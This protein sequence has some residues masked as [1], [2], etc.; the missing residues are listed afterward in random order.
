MSLNSDTLALTANA[1]QYSASENDYFKCYTAT[2]T[3]S[4]PIFIVKLIFTSDSGNKLRVNGVLLAS[5]YNTLLSLAASSTF[6][7]GAESPLILENLLSNAAGQNSALQWKSYQEDRNSIWVLAMKTPRQQIAT[8][9]E[10]SGKRRMSLCFINFWP[11]FSTTDGIVLPLLNDS[12]VTSDVHSADVI[13]T[14]CHN[15]A[16]EKDC[17]FLVSTTTHKDVYACVT[18]PL[19]HYSHYTNF[20]NLIRSGCFKGVFGCVPMSPASGFFKFPL[21]LNYFKYRDHHIYQDTNQ[22]AKHTTMDKLC[23]KNFCTLI[24]SHDDGGSREGIFDVLSAIA[25]I[26]SPGKYKNNTSNTRLNSIGN[27]KYI[28]EFV[29]HICPVS[30]YCTKI[31][32]YNVEKLLNCCL[33]GAIPIYY[34]EIDDIDKEIFNVHRI[35]CYDPK[36]LE[37]I[38]AVRS[39]VDALWRD[40]DKLLQFYRQAIFQ[41]SAHLACMRM[42]N[43]LQTMLA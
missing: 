29:F 37:S 33:G 31:P 16:N 18:E 12:A 15:I 34:G 27:V 22:N 13:I 2:I 11:G 32:G 21:Y 7:I 41:D 36:Q 14:G 40:K 19:E 38:D 20:L 3:N 43:A 30:F 28:S 26:D 23:S 8:M 42:E 35:L 6:S 9:R 1:C 5:S 39:K 10:L 24:S 17:A 25:R 4:E